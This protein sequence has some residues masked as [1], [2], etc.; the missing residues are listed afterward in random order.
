MLSKAMIQEFMVVTTRSLSS[1]GSDLLKALVGSM[2]FFSIF[3]D[4]D[5]AAPASPL[6]TRT[7]KGPLTLKQPIKKPTMREKSSSSD[8]LKNGLRSE[9][10][11]PRL[12]MGSHR[13]VGDR[14]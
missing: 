6:K 9:M 1:F 10:L 7:G 13:I 2:S 4:M 14:R 11:P 12:G 5:F 3:V 8:T